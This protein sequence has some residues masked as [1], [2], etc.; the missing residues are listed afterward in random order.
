MKSKNII[1]LMLC[2]LLPL[3]F[4]SCNDDDDDPITRTDASQL[5][6]GIFE[7]NIV[8]ASGVERATDVVVTIDR[9]DNDEIQAVSVHLTSASL[10]MDQTAVFNVGKAGNDRY[11]F[12]AG[13]TSVTAKSGGYLEGGNLTLY[14][15]MTSKFKISTASAAKMYTFSCTKTTNEQ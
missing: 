13:T 2:L 9:I 5:V 15:T 3:G 11:V 12:A 6:S 4:V 7:G 14:I 10:N 1:F 8:D